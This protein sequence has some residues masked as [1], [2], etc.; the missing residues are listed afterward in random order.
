MNCVMG[1]S[2]LSQSFKLVEFYHSILAQCSMLNEAGP[3]GQASV[4]GFSIQRQPTDMQVPLMF[5]SLLRKGTPDKDRSEAKLASAFDFMA[6]ALK[7][8]HGMP[9]Q[10]GIW[11]LVNLQGHWSAEM[12]H[13]LVR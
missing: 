9:L 12:K 6:N 8:E 7:K 13:D 5:V 2:V 4:S 10:V 3:G 1:F 11:K